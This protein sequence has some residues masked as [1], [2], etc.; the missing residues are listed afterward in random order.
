MLRTATSPWRP[1][2]W[3]LGSLGLLLLLGLA[4]AATAAPPGQAW[5]SLGLHALHLGLGLAVFLAALSVPVER[6]RQCAPGALLAV[7]M[8]LAGMLLDGRLSVSAFGA[9]RWVSVAGFHF[10]PSAFLQFLWPVALASWAARD[11]LRLRSP[12]ALL[13]LF[14]VFAFLAAPVLLQPDLGSVLILFGVTGI[15]LVFAG[16]PLAYLRWLAPAAVGIAALASL[17]FDHVVQRVVGFLRDEPY[18]LRM[19]WE[20]LQLGG[21]TGRGP[22]RGLVK[23]YIPEGDT[24]FILAVL[25]EEWGLP[26]TLAVWILFLVFTCAAVQVAR[27]APRRYGAIL[28]ASAAVMISVQ[29]AINMAVVTGAVPPKGLPLPFISR[30]GSAVLAL[31]A[32]LG[33]ALRAALEERRPRPVL[34]AA[35]PGPRLRS[36]PLLPSEG[37]PRPA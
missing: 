20:A 36:W 16:A 17:L 18:Q 26:G 32:L 29:A 8:L 23:G 3:M 33:V 34:E 2:C 15:T 10:Q 24:D 1:A 35:A 28:M 9:S 19:A 4:A 13:R 37:P 22:G 6:V 7:W 11:P 27:R 30:G 21:L 31:S 25:G 12:R 5:Q 14:L